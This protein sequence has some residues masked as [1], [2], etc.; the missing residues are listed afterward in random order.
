MK[1][2]QYEAAE[3][4]KLFRWAD[5]MSARFP[6]FKMLYHILMAAAEIK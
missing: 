3:Q 2:K 5:F 6:E 1:K 4:I